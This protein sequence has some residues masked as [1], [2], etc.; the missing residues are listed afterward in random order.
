MVFC[1]E[2]HSID[3]NGF[4]KKSGEVDGLRIYRVKQCCTKTE[5]WVLRQ[6]VTGLGSQL[7]DLLIL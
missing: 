5:A 2:F 1:Q 4:E 7:Y 6:N 3:S